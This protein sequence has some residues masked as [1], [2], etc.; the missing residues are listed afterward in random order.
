MVAS[1]LSALFS[2]GDVGCGAVRGLIQ[3]FAGFV[4]RGGGQHADEP[5]SMEAW[6]L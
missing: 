1:G 5:V 6:S 3:A 4:Q 2:A